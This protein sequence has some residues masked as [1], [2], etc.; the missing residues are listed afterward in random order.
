[1]NSGDLA[2]W[3]LKAFGAVVAVAAV[4]LG[5]SRY[6]TWKAWRTRKKEAEIERVAAKMRR[7]A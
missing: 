3:L 7:T 5:P 6:K 2:L 1:M 4:F